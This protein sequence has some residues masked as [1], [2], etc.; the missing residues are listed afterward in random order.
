M[1]ILEALNIK[2]II[3]NDNYVEAKMYITKFHNQGF[4]IVHGGLT[5]AFAETLAGYASN[6]I[7]S[8]DLLA[9][10]QTIIAN[11]I[12]TKSIDGYIKA[13][14]KLVHKGKR[15]HLW[16]VELVDDNG[17]LISLVDVTNSII[18]KKF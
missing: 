8:D 16:R 5:I 10:G 3:L 6:K 18:I 15:T 13:K 1:N 2:D 4:G 17:R 9:V 14:A 11:H 7:T 12:S